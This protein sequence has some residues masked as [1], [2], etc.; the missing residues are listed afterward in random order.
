MKSA[1]ILLLIIHGCTT[2]RV[3]VSAYN[4]E[5]ECRQALDKGNQEQ[6][7][8]TNVSS[9]CASVDYLLKEDK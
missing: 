8:F 5:I 4:S 3:H 1:W 2:E 9:Q 6:S 7:F